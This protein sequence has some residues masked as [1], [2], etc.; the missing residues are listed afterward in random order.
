ML[1][2]ET[3]LSRHLRHRFPPLIADLCVFTLKQAWACLFGASLLIAMILSRM[4]WTNGFPIARYDSLMAF[5]IL[6]QATFLKFGLESWAEVRVIALFHITGTIMEIFKIHAGSWTYPDPGLFKVFDVPLYSGFMYAA[7]GSYVARV[8]RLFEMDFT[9]FPPWPLHFAFAGMIYLNFFSHHFI[10]DLRYVLFAATIVIYARTRIWFR[11]GQNWHWMP[12][13]LAAFFSSF[14]LWLAENIGTMTGTWL[15]TGQNPF[16]V[17]SFAK[18]G[19]WY[20]LLYV[21]FATVT[22]VV[23]ITQGRAAPTRTQRP[24]TPKSEPPRR[25]PASQVS[26]P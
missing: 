7:V 11:I 10:L 12:L 25:S 24:Q 18:M 13:P 9:P 1:L 15:Y 14:F 6:L 22:L 20:L 16:D 3:R 23:P 8:I 4:I 26:A 17:V 5:A 2:I 19:S 21:A